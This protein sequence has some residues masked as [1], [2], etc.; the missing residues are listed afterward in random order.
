MSSSWNQNPTLGQSGMT[1]IHKSWSSLGHL[2]N[3]KGRVVEGWRAPWNLVCICGTLL[4]WHWQLQLVPANR[5]ESEIKEDTSKYRASWGVGPITHGRG[6]TCLG[7]RI[8]L[9]V[10]TFHLKILFLI[11]KIITYILW[12]IYKLQNTSRNPTTKY[13]SFIFIW[14]LIKWLPY[15]RHCAGSCE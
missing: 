12:N 4:Q 7:L 5:G 1:H 15:A 10:F 11:L 13:Y 6:P 14:L 8:T 2:V 9:W 3:P